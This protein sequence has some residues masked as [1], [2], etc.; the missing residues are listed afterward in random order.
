MGIRPESEPTLE[1]VAAKP[2]PAVSKAERLGLQVT[3]ER[4]VT[5]VVP[6]EARAQPAEIPAGAV[7]VRAEA[8]EAPGEAAE[9]P[10]EAAEAPAG[11]VEAR[12]EAAEAPGEAAVQAAVEQVE[13]GLV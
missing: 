6:R 4:R 13:P 10:G 9:A 8:A 7:E 5:V 1:E 12:A 11:A 3:E 2:G